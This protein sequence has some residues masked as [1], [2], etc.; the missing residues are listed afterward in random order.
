TT[1][2]R[3]HHRFFR[4][5]RAVVRPVAARLKAL[6]A[7]RRVALQMLVAGL[8]ADAELL[9]QTRHRET[10]RLR[11]T[12]KANDLFHGGY[13][14]PGHVALCVTHLP[15]LSVTYLPGSNHQQLYVW[16][17]SLRRFTQAIPLSGSANRFTYS[18]DLDRV[19][20]GYGDGRITQV[21]LGDSHPTE[22]PFT[23]I[24]YVANVLVAA[25]ERLL[26]IDAH[27]NR[28][29][30]LVFGSDGQLIKRLPRSINPGSTTWD[31]FRQRFYFSRGSDNGSAPEY[32]TLADDSTLGPPQ[33][34]EYIG[35]G[36]SL[37]I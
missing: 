28:A 26:T 14:F 25:G 1:L 35:G 8:A 33:P 32:A 20:L 17:I 23:R 36:N 15:G 16:S 3:S 4:A 6:Q 27:Y 13:F 29:A 31:A 9:A 24:P 18:P 12:D 22:R 10:A 30:Y 2:F 11:Q 19:Y 5:L 34:F 37:P 21:S 7:V